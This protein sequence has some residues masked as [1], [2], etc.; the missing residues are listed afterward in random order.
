MSSAIDKAVKSVEDRAAEPEAE[1]RVDLQIG[2]N[3]RVAHL[4]LPL[5]LNADDILHLIV[6][7]PGF[8]AQANTQ[9]MAL[10]G[11]GGGIALPNGQLHAVP[12][13]TKE[14]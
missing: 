6:A 9:Y 3:G 14:L 7:L 8:I 2:I 12:P 13:I 1:T 11:G 10:R 5:P 4:N